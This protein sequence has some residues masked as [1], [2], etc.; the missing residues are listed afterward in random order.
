MAGYDIKGRNA[1]LQTNYFGTFQDLVCVKSWS[2]NVSA[3]LK[4]I[5]TD[6]S[7][8]AKDFDYDRYGYTLTASGLV[9]ILDGDGLPTFIDM[10]EVLIGFLELGFR[11]VFVDDNA[12][13][14]VI[15]GILIINNQ[16]LDSTPVRLLNSTL[17]ATGKGDLGIF[18][19]DET[20]VISFEINGVDFDAT[21]NLA[22]VTDVYKINDYSV[23]SLT[24]ATSEQQISVS[25]T[26]PKV[27]QPSFVGDYTSFPSVGLLNITYPTITD[28]GT[29]WNV[30]MIFDYAPSTL[31]KKYSLIPN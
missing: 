18:K 15:K 4:E 14:C 9:Q 26:V 24:T 22:E 6:G 29:H 27:S 21:N 1:I 13:S 19:P 20:T 28:T 17:S 30:T 12:N 10:L 31:N 16:S 2:I 23:L 3:D 5:T 11:L 8:L 25:F 7:G